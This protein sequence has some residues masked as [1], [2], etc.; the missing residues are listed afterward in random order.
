MYLNQQAGFAL[1]NSYAIEI[2]EIEIVTTAEDL[3]IQQEI[4]ETKEQKT[5]LGRE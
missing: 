1:C 3:D 4:V 5:E 2:V